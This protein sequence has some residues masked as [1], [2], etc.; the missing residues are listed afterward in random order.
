KARLIDESYAEDITQTAFLFLME[1]YDSL[2]WGNL[3]FW[4]LQVVDNLIKNKNRFEKNRDSI[5][6]IIN[7][8]DLKEN[9]LLYYERTS[10]VKDI[11]LRELSE[12][13]LDFFNTY[14]VLCESH[15][16]AAKKYNVSINAS[17]ARKCRIK[18]RVI[19]ILEENGVTPRGAI[20]K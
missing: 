11:I 17:K 12:T 10:Y 13:E 3:S 15:E 19:S 14:F 16:V 4:I 7:I 6:T 20:S 5:I 8:D 2:D 9:E 1:K 18:T